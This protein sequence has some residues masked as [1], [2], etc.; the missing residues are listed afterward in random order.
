L[1]ASRST[2]V[3][4]V[5]GAAVVVAVVDTAVVAIVSTVVSDALLV[6]GDSVGRVMSAPSSSPEQPAAA[7]VAP[8]PSSACDGRSHR[9]SPVRSRNGRAAIPPWVLR[10]RGRGN[11]KLTTCR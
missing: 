4:G 7:R 10:G 11:A 8:S 9:A 5:V 3:V 6:V 2:T 1:R